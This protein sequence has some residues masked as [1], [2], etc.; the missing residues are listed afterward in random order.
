MQKEPLNNQIAHLLKKV[1]GALERIESNTY[2]ICEEC[3]LS[4]GAAYLRSDPL[5]RIC[6]E[7][8][9]QDQQRAPERLRELITTNHASGPDAIM[10]A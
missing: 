2:G 3:H 5:V 6:L 9:S 1:D 10:A 7:H 4:I 8:L